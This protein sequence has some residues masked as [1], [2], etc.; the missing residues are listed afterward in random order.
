MI[1]LSRF[2]VRKRVI[3]FATTASVVATSFAL[4]QDPTATYHF[5]GCCPFNMQPIGLPMPTSN[6]SCLRMMPP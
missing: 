1:V 4:A 5:A 2:F 6:R 3:F